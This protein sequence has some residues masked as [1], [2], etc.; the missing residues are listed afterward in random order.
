MRFLDLDLDFFLNKNAY[1]SEQATARLG[2]DYKPWSA[3]K[4]RQFLEE[5]CCLSHDAPVRGR[6]VE[7]H[8][9]VFHFWRRLIESGGLRVPF[10]VI[11]IDAHPDLFVGS[12]LYLTSGF[13]YVEAERRHAILNEKI[14]SCG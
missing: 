5:R 1:G 9:G 8:D 12:E 7:T 2:S 3:S 6:T 10:D 13:L 11:H 4:V 14:H